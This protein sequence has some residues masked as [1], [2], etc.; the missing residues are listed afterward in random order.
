MFGNIKTPSLVPT[1]PKYCLVTYD[2]IKTRL[3]A[4]S[5]LLNFIT[6]FWLVGKRLV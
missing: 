1:S 5:M 2:Q 3:Q 4:Y 6:F